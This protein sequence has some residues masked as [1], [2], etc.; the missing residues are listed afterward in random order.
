MKN[1]L[2]LFMVLCIALAGTAVFAQDSLT[3]G[4]I[5]GDVVDSNG[6]AVP[7]AS[8][9]VTGALGERTT[10]TN[11]QGH[12]E[13]ANLIPGSY[14]IRVEKEGFKAGEVTEVTVLVGKT[15]TAKVALQ[16]GNI[17]EV[18]TVVGGGQGIDQANTA[19]R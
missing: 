19:T 10:I 11:D 17:S 6:G 15:S 14:T 12:F 18:V 8:V 9:K 4:S 13:V 2:K 5:S 16:A 1:V 3:T 7:G